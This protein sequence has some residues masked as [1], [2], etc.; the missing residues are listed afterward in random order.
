MTDPT[1]SLMERYVSP[2]GSNPFW[3]IKP[4]RPGKPTTVLM[5]NKILTIISSIEAI[6]S[7]AISIPTLRFPDLNC[8]CKRSSAL[9]WTSFSNHV[10]EDI[11]VVQEGVA[12]LLVLKFNLS[13][14]IPPLYQVFFSMIV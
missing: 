11:T 14:S 10:L 3:R 4:S 2:V 5:E 8:G 7:R 1:S 9:Y 12:I 13:E 6:V